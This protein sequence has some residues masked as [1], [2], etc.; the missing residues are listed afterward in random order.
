MFDVTCKDVIN[1][2]VAAAGG[3]DRGVLVHFEFQ[4]VSHERDEFC[5][6]G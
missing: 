4:V 3:R 2:S 1:T 6:I 5:T